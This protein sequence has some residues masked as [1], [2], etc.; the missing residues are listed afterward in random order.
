[1]ARIDVKA[2]KAFQRLMKLTAGYEEYTARVLLGIGARATF[3]LRQ[4]Y[5]SGD[6]LEFVN[7]V[8]EGKT[9]FRSKHG[10]KRMISRKMN[11]KGDKLRISSFVVNPFEKARKKASGGLFD[12]NPIYQ[13]ILTKKMVAMVIPKISGWGENYSKDIFKSDGII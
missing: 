2:D 12:D 13:K 6:Y 1:M 8:L 10:N 9:G 3:I 11:K 4:M 7:Y 5:T